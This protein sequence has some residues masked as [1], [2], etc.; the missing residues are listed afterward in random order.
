MDDERERAFALAGKQLQLPVFRVGDEGDYPLAAALAP[1]LRRPPGPPRRG[2]QRHGT[3]R[4]PEDLEHHDCIIH[5]LSR[6]NNSLEFSGP[7]GPISVPVS[8]R[9]TLNSFSMVRELALAGLGVAAMPAFLCAEDIRAGRLTTVLDDWSPSP[10]SLY[11]V[12]P[13]TQHLSAKVRAFLDFLTERMTPP[14]W[15]IS[16][17]E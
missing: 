10:G 6:G 16:T 3:P 4:T 12:Y 9:V 14:P 2:T 8:G 13:S 7:R 11:A 17:S 5:G 15:D 1:A